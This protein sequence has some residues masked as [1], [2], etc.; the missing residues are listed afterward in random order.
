MSTTGFNVDPDRFLWFM[1]SVL[2]PL[3]ISSQETD[4]TP[5][6]AI[7]DGRLL[8]ITEKYHSDF[9]ELLQNPNF[10]TEDDAS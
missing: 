7:Q 6:I 4:R 3:I 9:L 10:V 1:T 8:G 5:L 2:V